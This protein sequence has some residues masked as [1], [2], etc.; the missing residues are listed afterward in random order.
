LISFARYGDYEPKPTPQ[1]GK[2]RYS[3]EQLY[4]LSLYLYALEPP[5]NPNGMTAEGRRGEAIFARQGCVGCHPAPLYTNNKL[6]PAPGFEVPEAMRKTEAILEVSVGSD[7][8]LALQTRRGTGFYKVPSLR[9]VWMRSAFGHEG[10][11]ASLEEWFDPARLRE[12]YEPKGFHRG[13]GPIRG[14]EFGLRLGAADRTALIAFLKT[15]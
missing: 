14:H 1:D 6:S 4:A 8:G 11:A 7:P 5:N 9:G 12:D 15:L 13:A 2:T 3:I 10:S